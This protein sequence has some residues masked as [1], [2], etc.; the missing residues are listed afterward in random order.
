[1]ACAV[2]LYAVLGVNVAFCDYFFSYILVCLL[3]LFL[4]VHSNL[5]Y[6]AIMAT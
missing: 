4:N 1:M 3:F 5:F 2:V 6:D